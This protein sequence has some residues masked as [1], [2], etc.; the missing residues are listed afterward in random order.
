MHI[1]VLFSVYFSIYLCYVVAIQL[2]GF[3]TYEYLI[4]L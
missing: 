1:D 3:Y 4:I 2:F